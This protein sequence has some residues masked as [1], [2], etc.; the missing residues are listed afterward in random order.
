MW[1]DTEWRHASTQPRQVLQVAEPKVLS[2]RDMKTTQAQDLW[3]L[4]MAWIGSFWK[5]LGNADRGRSY[6]D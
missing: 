4:F 3:P 2:L 6:Q 5:S 1:F